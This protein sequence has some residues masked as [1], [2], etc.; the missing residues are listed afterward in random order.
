MEKLKIYARTVEDEAVQQINAMNESEAYKDCLVRIMPD[1]HAGAGC[2]IGTVVAI[3]DRIVPNTVGVDIG[4]GMYVV[5]WTDKDI[6]LERLDEVIRSFVP[7][8]F[9]IHENPVM[10]FDYSGFRCQDIIDEKMAN[11]SI[12]S[13][14]GGNHFIEVDVDSQGFK[15]LIIHSGSRNL[16]LRVCKYYQDKAIK[17]CK[18]KA[19][20]EK[21]LIEKLKAEGREKEIAAA[22][23][24]AKAE[25][26]P[27]DPQL[28]YLEGQDMEDY[29]HDMA[30]C[31]KYAK[32]NRICIAMTIAKQ[33]EDDEL[34]TNLVRPGG[35]FHTIHNYIY[36]EHR[37]LRKGAV[38]ALY[39]ELLIIPMNM[40]DGSLVCIGKGNIDWLYSAPHGAGRL[41]SRKKAKEIIA[42]AD[43]EQSMDGIF[44]SSVC[45]ETLD[46]A[47]MVYKP[48][49]EIIDCVGDTVDVKDVIKPI[50]NFKAK[51]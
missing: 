4:C 32:R 21:A 27:I 15:Y 34:M 45:A 1:C 26:K 11:C 16:G 14:G 48:I 41:M 3:K 25:Y 24:K 12:G 19:L 31:Q 38:R 36:I 29:L 46:E 9:N 30:L 8:G 43:Y 40:R 47:P 20:D 7:S 5:R 42:L 44:T 37:I 51:E 39:N 17:Y 22:I 23:A 18:S 35:A 50:Y 10:D 49:Q 28:A 13:L 6:D 33:M 2:T